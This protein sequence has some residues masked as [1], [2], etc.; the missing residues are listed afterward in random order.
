MLIL[1][2]VGFV[3]YLMDMV[4]NITHFWILHQL[5]ISGIS[6]V[7]SWCIILFIYLWVLLTCILMIFV[8]VF[9]IIPVILISCLVL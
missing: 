6:L 4:S 8:P 9:V 5:C 3:L 2:R 7:W 1:R